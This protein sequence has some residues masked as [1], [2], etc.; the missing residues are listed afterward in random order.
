MKQIFAAFTGARKATDDELS[1]MCKTI[2]LIANLGFSFR[3]G[4][5]IGFDDFVGSYLDFA[6]SQDK[7]KHLRREKFRPDDRIGCIDIRTLPNY[8]LAEAICY[9]VMP[10][11][12]YVKDAFVRDLM[13]R[14]LYILL[15]KDFTNPSRILFSY[16]NELARGTK[17]TVLLAK[18]FGIPNIELFNGVGKKPYM[19][20]EDEIRLTYIPEDQP[21][22]IRRQDIV[23]L[24]IDFYKDDPELFKHISKS[25]GLEKYIDL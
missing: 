21:L 14:N 17:A 5:A 19:P 6:H 15:G 22:E 12:K 9:L 11:L 4:A 20:D 13:I 2:M 24:I 25:F 23:D 16:T 1:P 7:L 3:D 18:Q 10:N 8:P